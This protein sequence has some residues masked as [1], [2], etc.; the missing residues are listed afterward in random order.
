MC[1]EV[2]DEREYIRGFECSTS[3]IN[4]VTYTCT[5]DDSPPEDCE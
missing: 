1:F 2:I 5:Y 3:G 4:E